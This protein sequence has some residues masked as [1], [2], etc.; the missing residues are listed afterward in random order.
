MNINQY[1]DHKAEFEGQIRARIA[2]TPRYTA[3]IQYT[4]DPQ[5]AFALKHE[6]FFK[7]PPPPEPVPQPPPLTDEEIKAGVVRTP[8]VVK[9][10]Y[11]VA[12]MQILSPT[13]FTIS[14][15]FFDVAGVLDWF[16]NAPSDTTCKA[17][18]FIV[19]DS[20]RDQAQGPIHK[21]ITYDRAQYEGWLNEATVEMAALGAFKLACRHEDLQTEATSPGARNTDLPPIAPFIATQLAGPKVDA[22]GI[23]SL[24]HHISDTAVAG[25]FFPKT[26]FHPNG[27]TRTVKSVDE[28]KTARA[29]GFTDEP[30]TKVPAPV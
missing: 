3:S 26:L 15:S 23:G 24:T 1:A 25:S 18:Q 5:G 6:E 7:V 20:L 30:A 10:D 29:D 22:A 27:K 17:V 21:S 8:V 2:A 4:G 14:R 28:E 13:E 16:A 11:G 9:E 19:H 12:K